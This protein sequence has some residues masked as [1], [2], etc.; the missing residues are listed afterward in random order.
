MG[1][2]K[3]VDDLRVERQGLSLHLTIGSGMKVEISCVVFGS[4]LD[5]SLI[6]LRVSQNLGDFSIE[7]T[8]FLYSNDSD[9][10]HR[11]FIRQFYGNI[12]SS[13]N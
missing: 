6:Y 10:I 9:L 12:A 7:L 2:L 11:Q 13:T 3:H 4:T 1:R 5:E 8:Y